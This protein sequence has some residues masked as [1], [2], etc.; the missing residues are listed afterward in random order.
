MSQTLEDL[1]QL[2]HDTYEAAA[3]K[4]G[5][6]T[7]ERSRQSWAFV[8]EENKATMREAVA[9]VAE[10]V[11]AEERAKH[12]PE[13]VQSDIRQIMEALDINTHGRSQSPHELVQKEILPKIRK[14]KKTFVDVN[15]A[16]GKNYVEIR[17]LLNGR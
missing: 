13:A 16:L 3:V 9:V 8:P 4:N 2:M 5:W 6:Y 1:C 14:M 15:T 10:A 17:D 7:N 11:R 12:G